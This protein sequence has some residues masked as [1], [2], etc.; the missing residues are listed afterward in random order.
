MGFEGINDPKEATD[1]EILARDGCNTR[2][3][4]VE[5]QDQAFPEQ[6]NAYQM[7]FDLIGNYLG[8]YLTHTKPAWSNKS[9]ANFNAPDN[10]AAYPARTLSPSIAKAFSSIAQYTQED[11]LE[12]HWALIIRAKALLH[13]TDLYGPF[14]VGLS[15]SEKSSYDAQGDIYKA[16]LKDLDKATD[17]LRLANDDNKKSFHATTDKIYGG[18]INKWIKFANS[19]KLRM[20]IRMRFV[21]PELAKTVAEKAVREGVIESN[22]DNAYRVYNPLGLYKTSVE[23]GD[24]RMCAD[25]DAYMSGYNDPR[26]A[27]YFKNAKQISSRAIIGCLA[28]SEITDN[29]TAK[30]L[31]SAANIQANGK[32]VWLTAAEMYFCRA[33]GALE[34]WEMNGNAEN[35]YNQGIKTSFE[36]WGAI[37]AE[38]YIQN[39]TDRPMAYVDATGGFGSTQPA[40]SE[41]TIK[42]AEDGSQLERIITQKWIALFPLGQEAWCELRR[43]GFPKVFD[44]QTSKNG[45]SLKVP[46]RIPFDVNERTNNAEAYKDALQKLGGLDN[47]DTKMWW[48]RP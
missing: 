29:E 28:G 37:G 12:Y 8:R 31:Y 1:A 3:F 7:N 20:A 48:Q 11:G 21:E 43:T 5:L 33:E 13:L 40:P 47:Y 36:Q 41:I 17:F 22:E 2:S 39:S 14:P 19:L 38:E 30:K 9:F 25:I 15:G 42:W 34:G 27:K 24:S 44:I 46:N 6:E 35:L 32:G 18:N 4:L 26:L 16:L 10:W 23:W 45:S